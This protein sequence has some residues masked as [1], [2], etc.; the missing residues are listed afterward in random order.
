M[1]Y[2]AG[3]DIGLDTATGLKSK[4]SKGD[5]LKA[6]GKDNGPVQLH[7]VPAPPAG[8]PPGAEEEE[9]AEDGLV[10][11]LET[12]EVGK[13]D[14]VDREIEA[15]VRKLERKGVRGGDKGG[16]H[17][18]AQTGAAGSTR[19]ERLQRAGAG[20]RKQE[21]Q[22]KFGSKRG[23][24]GK[25]GRKTDAERGEGG[26]V[27][28]FI[29]R[30]LQRPAGRERQSACLSSDR[31]PVGCAGSRPRP[32]AWPEVGRMLR[33][34]GKVGEEQGMVGWEAE[35][36]RGEGDTRSGLSLV[37]GQNGIT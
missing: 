24:R 23:G 5:Q 25:A 35:P 34:A 18:P 10:A 21:Q 22:V 15:A 12:K 36:S 9:G 7:K 33:G 1:L 28:V 27:E 14:A 16:E 2:P 13:K 8:A 30:L 11:A 17:V 20:S 26:K 37:W 4:M 32:A 6:G 19:G 29:W 31:L 3:I